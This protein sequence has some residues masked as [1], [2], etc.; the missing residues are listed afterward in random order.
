MVFR[1]W[2]RCNIVNVVKEMEGEL[3]ECD[4]GE[5]PNIRGRIKNINVYMI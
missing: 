4:K 3:I 5:I 1:V 2:K